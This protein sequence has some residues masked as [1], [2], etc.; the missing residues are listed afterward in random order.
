[1]SASPAPRI[2]RFPSQ[3]VKPKPRRK[4]RFPL[5]LFFLGVVLVYFGYTFSVQAMHWREIVAEEKL[6]N[7]RIADLAVEMRQLQRE[8]ELLGTDEY[9]ERLARER[10]GLV[11]PQDIIVIPVYTDQGQ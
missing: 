2:V 6:L 10:L 7:D 3:N 4:R 1:M 5:S 9:I 11:R 8:V